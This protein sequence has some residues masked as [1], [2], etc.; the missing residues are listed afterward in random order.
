M[1]KFIT[2]LAILIAIFSCGA[3]PVN[4]SNSE[5]AKNE[6]KPEKIAT[7]NPKIVVDWTGYSSNNI[8][9]LINID[10]TFQLFGL[11]SYARAEHTQKKKYQN[12]YLFFYK[13]NAPKKLPIPELQQT[14]PNN[15]NTTGL[16]GALEF[17][18]RTKPEMTVTII[19]EGYYEIHQGYSG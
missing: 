1:Y 4:E 17:V 9:K 3:P 15:P 12:I 14:D 6:I 16:N 7:G 18:K 8:I 5:K 19:G 11:M 10:S 2:L 13:G